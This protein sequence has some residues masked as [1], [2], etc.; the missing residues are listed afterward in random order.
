MMS[1]RTITSIALAVTL[2]CTSTLAGNTAFASDL[3]TSGYSVADV[4]ATTTIPA[5]SGML[6]RESLPSLTNSQYLEAKTAISE[7]QSNPQV[8]QLI[9][10]L[11][12]L[13]P[14]ESVQISSG[15]APFTVVKTS[16]GY[17]LEGIYS[18]RSVCSWSI[19]TVLYGLGAVGLFALAATLGPG[20]VAVVAGVEMTAEQLGFAAATSGSIS[21]LAAWADSKFCG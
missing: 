10:Q 14:G 19:A 4:N 7:A 2:A 11:Q 15:R 12:S 13:K 5:A 6:P 18:D 20:E 16:N 17:A 9:A 8:S 3:G 21:A 1:A